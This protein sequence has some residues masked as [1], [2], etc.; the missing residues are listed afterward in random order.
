MISE[1][2]APQPP[3][4][5]PAPVRLEAS[6]IAVTDDADETGSQAEDEPGA[7][8]SFEELVADIGQKT[9]APAIEDEVSQAV[10]AAVE[11][12]EDPVF[13]TEPFEPEPFETAIVEPAA[14]TEPPATIE[15]EP[16][17]GF[18][19]ELPPPPLADP[20]AL[21][22]EPAPQ[23]ATPAGPADP[24]P[25]PPI[26]DPEEPAMAQS[27]PSV[28]LTEDSTADAAASALARLVSK[29]DMGSENTLE[30]IVRELLKPM[31]KEWLDQNL[32]QIVE[33]KVEAEVQ[34]I[35]RLAR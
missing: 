23:A 2:D 8:L 1:D 16:L 22:P 18:E 17:A 11:V 14:V 31:L 29:M 9:A 27:A 28:S 21:E 10:S 15:T 26:R 30:G 5:E 6:D 24:A 4:D 13:E 19:E 32:P 33:E 12:D 7:G 34:R 3:R 25:T 20:V 35:A